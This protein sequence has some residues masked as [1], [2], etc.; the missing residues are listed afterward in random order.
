MAVNLSPIGGVAAQF[1]DNSGNVLS[2]GKIFTYAAGTTTPQATYT[3]AAGTTALANPI[4]LDAAGRVPT[5]EIWLTDGLQYKFII[6]TSTDVQIGSYDNIVG[7]NSN[8]VNYTNSQE[9]QTAT[10][11]QTVFTLTTMQYQPGTN[12]LSVFVDGVNQYGP[13][14]LYAYTETSSTVV[15]F[16]SGLHVGASVKFTTSNINAS[17]A[18]DAEQV[19]YIPPFTG[20]VATNVE[21]KL[22]QTVS[23]E[24]FGAVGNGVADDTSAFAA[25]ILAAAGRPIVLNGG[26]YRVDTLASSP[27]TTSVNIEGSGT[28]DGN[29]NASAYFNIGGS[30]A[31]FRCANIKMQNMRAAALASSS[32]HVISRVEIENTT[33]VD[34]RT[35]YDFNCIVSSAEVRGNVFSNLSSSTDVNAVRFGNNSWATQAQQD[36]AI[37]ANSFD[38]LEKT[39]NDGECHAIL[40]YGKHIRIFGNRVEN[41]QNTGN[42]LGAEGIYTKALEAVVSGNTLIDAGTGEA[43]I[44]LKG[45]DANT[46]RIVCTANTLLCVSVTPTTGIN[47][48]TDQAIVSNNYLENMGNYGIRSPRRNI[49]DALVQGNT[50]KNSVNVAIM[51]EGYGQN[52]VINSNMV[53]GVTGEYGGGLAAGIYVHNEDN[54]LGN[55]ISALAV[56]GNTVRITTNSALTHLSGVHVRTLSN[57]IYARVD[58][59]DNTTEVDGSAA[60]IRDVWVQNAGA[61]V[62]VNVD[63]SQSPNV[64]KSLDIS[65][66]ATITTLNVEWSGTGSPESQIYASP[67]SLWRSTNGGAG[68]S[69]YVKQSAVTLN[70]GWSG[71]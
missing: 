2:G 48:S 45:E 47:I 5:G 62:T 53:D 35:G 34:S 27:I 33:V 19:S 61:M 46:R 24:D 54:V 64:T 43:Y 40:A 10:A 41:V 7:I 42:G 31:L 57:Q 50:I 9:F 30:I 8:F 37:Y 58:V 18:T 21:A 4:I 20:G 66:A 3:S 39:T 22:E 23:V 70:T 44:N 11:G 17:A 49:I 32:A 15:T 16:T 26:T 36:Y 55:D 29:N 13:G 1:F 14:A 67:G 56:K 65:G 63:G 68:T 69:L 12:S 25:A 71:K 60:N 28:L 6:K 52:V 59:Q 38:T 51:W